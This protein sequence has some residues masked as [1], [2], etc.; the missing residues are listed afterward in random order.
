MCGRNGSHGELG[1][2]K[3]EKGGRE[4]GG[5]G[6]GGGGGAGRRVKQSR[7]ES[8]KTEASSKATVVEVGLHVGVP[9]LRFT[10]RRESQTRLDD[11]D[12]KSVV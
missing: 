9:D 8:R 4:T 5:G 1:R 6:G 2:G 3:K 10:L 12:R 11:L 7:G